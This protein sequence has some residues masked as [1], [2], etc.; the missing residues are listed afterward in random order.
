MN[1]ALASA[2]MSEKVISWTARSVPEFCDRLKNAIILNIV[3]LSFLLYFTFCFTVLPPR[4]ITNED[5]QQQQ[6]Q[7]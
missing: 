7:Q 6:Q 5:F 4:L 3:T 1:G 2:H